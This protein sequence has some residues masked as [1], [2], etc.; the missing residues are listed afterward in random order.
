MSDVLKRRA[1]RP[2]AD[3][4]SSYRKTS[5]FIEMSVAENLWLDSEIVEF[6]ALVPEIITAHVFREVTS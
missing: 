1:I 5:G 2:W 6:R 3:N 4:A